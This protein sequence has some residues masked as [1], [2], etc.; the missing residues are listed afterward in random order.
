[1]SE[2]KQKDRKINPPINTLLLKSEL[3]PNFI[4]HTEMYILGVLLEHIYPFYTPKIIEL[5]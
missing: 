2:P 1:M 5:A 3:Y 4:L